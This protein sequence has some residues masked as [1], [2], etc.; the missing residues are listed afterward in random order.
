MDLNGSKWT[1]LLDLEI[2]A[3]SFGAKI[4]LILFSSKRLQ[5]RLHGHD[6]LIRIF[7]DLI[8]KARN[9]PIPIFL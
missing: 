8:I 4:S 5:K 2:L 3:L 6:K 7:R 9:I 1:F